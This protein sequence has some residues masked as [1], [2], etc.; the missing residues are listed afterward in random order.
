MT[1]YAETVF[2][3]NFFIDFFIFVLTVKI[4]GGRI[5]KTRIITASAL[6]GVVSAIVP[7]LHKYTFIIKIV[8]IIIFPF[9]IKKHDYFRSY[10]VTLSVFLIT[11]FIL[12][13]I[14]YALKCSVN[15]R[16][17]YIISYGPVPIL[18]SLSGLCLLI[19]L[20]ELKKRF[21]PERNRNSNK[22]KVV[23]FDDRVRYSGEAYYDSGNRVYAN[24]D[25]PVTVV[26]GKVYNVF[27]GNEDEVAISTVSGITV[28]KTKDVKIKIYSEDGNNIIYKT[29]IALAPT[30]TG[31]EI[32]LHGD[33]EVK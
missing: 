29:K 5:V 16:I 24:N 21:I 18:F 12:G 3:S 32:I 27:H 15:N 33:M 13:G 23:L 30:V 8:C 2:L 19:M 22:R 28:L 31:N 20:S 10:L 4:T 6:G 17:Y 11:T 7:V 14:S 1:I 26:S 9:L 25:D